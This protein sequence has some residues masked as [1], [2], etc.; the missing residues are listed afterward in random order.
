LRE[1]RSTSLDDMMNDA[2]EVEVNLMASGKIKSNSDRDMNKVQD[3]A[4]PS[5]SQTSEERFEMMMKT[6]E[7]MMER[8]ALDNNPNTREQADVP[9]RNQRRPTVPQIRQR[10]QRNQ[11]DQQIRPPFQNNYVNENYDDNFE[12]NMHCCDGD[13]TEVFLTKEEH[14]QFMDANEIFMQEN[15]ERLSVEREDYQTGLQNAIMQF[16][17]QYN[18]R[19][20][21]VPANPP[22]GNPPKGNPTKEAQNNIPSS[23][24]PKKDSAAKDVVDKGKQKE[25]SQKKVP[26]TRKETVTKEVEKTSSSFNFESEMA[27]I[28]I[29][30]PFN[31]LIKNNEYRN[32]IIKMLKMEQT[33]DTLN[34]QDD[35]PAI[36]FGPRV[37]ENS[38]AEEVPPF[39]VS[40]KIHDMTLHNAMLD[41]GASH[42]LMPKVVMDQLGLDITRP[43][44]DLFSF[45]S[46][47]VKCLRPNQ[48]SGGVFV[49]NSSKEY[50]HGCSGC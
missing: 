34:I 1:R 14:D 19:N 49:S 2:I 25:E 47:K 6:M 24:Q 15:D 43:Y 46:R 27:K 45:D 36:L 23:S 22:K 39:Y 37:E 7:K 5:T 33:S 28:K 48:R 12:D 21:K 30:V 13:E 16:Q 31:E 4:Q 41:S 29:Y 35:H 44:K 26:E 40:L 8:M 10:D 11:G 38:D 3:K 17:R 9:P 18:L 50:G 42:N 20:Q 32:Q